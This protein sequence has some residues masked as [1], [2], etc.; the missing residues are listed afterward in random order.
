M[1]NPKTLLNIAHPAWL[2]SVL[3]SFSAGV[4]GI[5]LLLMIS[6]GFNV[7]GLFTEKLYEYFDLNKAI[8]VDS[9]TSVCTIYNLKP[10]LKFAHLA[11]FKFS[12]APVLRW[13]N[14]HGAATNDTTRI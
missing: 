1:I 12:L 11:W 8:F 7:T 5:V 13:S 4:I 2:N 14:W 9:S 6:P 3:L 10:L